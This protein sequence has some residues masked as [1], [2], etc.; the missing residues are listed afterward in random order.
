MTPSQLRTLITRYRKAHNLASF[1]KAAEAVSRDIGM[2]PSS[3]WKLLSGVNAI[4]PMVEMA[5]KKI[6]IKPQT[7]GEEGDR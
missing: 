3:I 4:R 5:L 2:Q 1:T 7:I 6:S